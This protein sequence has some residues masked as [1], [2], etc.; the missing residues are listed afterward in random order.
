MVSLGDYCHRSHSH[1]AAARVSPHVHSTALIGCCAPLCI[2][3]MRWW[4]GQLVFI[5]HVS[6]PFVGLCWRIACCH[7]QAH[8]LCGEGV[9]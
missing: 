4:V 3:Y 2:V 5:I 9:A 6:V 1:A 8:C 7:P